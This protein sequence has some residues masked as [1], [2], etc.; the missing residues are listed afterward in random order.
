MIC[1][2]AKPGYQKIDIK[3]YVKARSCYYLSVNEEML[4]AR[5][6]LEYSEILYVLGGEVHLTV[7]DTAYTI[8]AG[9]L[10]V[11]PNYRTVVGF[12]QSSG[13]TSFCT[14]EFTC[15]DEM[16]EGISER[17]ISVKED[18]F[19]INKLFTR[20]SETM[21]ESSGNQNY[22]GD[23]IL[24]SLLYT[25]RRNAEIDDRSNFSLMVSVMEYINGNIGTML[26]VDDIAAHF[27]YNK[28]YLARNFRARYGITVRKYVNDRKISMAKRLLATTD[29]SVQKIGESIGFP[30]TELFEK[31]FRYHEKVTPQRFRKMHR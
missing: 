29:V 7:G 2:P 1:L 8:G 31:Y 15:S 28:D 20:L 5:R 3:T 13:K 27:G 14:A 11:I 25:I 22:E 26:T 21:M 18:G 17:V 12:R 9:E 4:Y 23:A 19:F 24:L 10:L 30:E 16:T 6:F